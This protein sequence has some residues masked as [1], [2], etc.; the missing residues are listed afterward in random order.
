MIVMPSGCT[1]WIWHSLARETGRIGHLYSPTH[2]RGPWPWFP[3]ALDNG[4][5]GCWD[6]DTNVFDYEKWNT[7]E[8][9]WKRLLFWAQAAAIKPLWAIVPDV[10]GNAKETILRWSKYAGEIKAS[11]IPLAVAVQD[12]MTVSDIEFLNPR[13]D[14][15]CV[16]GTTEW[17]WQTVEQ[18]AKAGRCH[19]LRCSDPEKLDYLQSLGVES[20]DSTAW[21]RGDRHKRL[22]GLETWCRKH[23]NPINQPLWPYACRGQDKHQLT[24]A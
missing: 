5:F 16:G 13:Y 1:G 3:Y 22:A 7:R 17:K 21:N 12:G 14:V 2:Q 9:D 10:P 11:G 18:W 15:I 24:F 4:A 8:D 6:P 23:G 19:L 20:C